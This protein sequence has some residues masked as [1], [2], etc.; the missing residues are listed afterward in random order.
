MD[1]DEFY[2]KWD[3]EALSSPVDAKKRVEFFEDVENRRIQMIVKCERCRK[4]LTIKVIDQPWPG[5]YVC[6][7][8]NC[9]KGNKEI[10]ISKAAGS[11]T[12]QDG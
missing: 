8:D 3:K 9:A 7:D 5:G 6:D 2:K 4:V 10:H 1:S 12:E 11:S